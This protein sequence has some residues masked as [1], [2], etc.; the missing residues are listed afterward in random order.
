MGST[1]PPALLSAEASKP[2]QART[3][4]GFRLEF[5]EQ[6]EGVCAFALRLGVAGGTA[7]AVIDR[8]ID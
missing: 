7:G 6:K 4:L 8:L 3:D 2:E 1:P 5:S